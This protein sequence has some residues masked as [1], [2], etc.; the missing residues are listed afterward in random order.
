LGVSKEVPVG[1]QNIRLIVTLDTDAS[2]EQ[3]TTLLRLTE[4]YCV[5]YQTLLHAAKLSATYNRT[6]A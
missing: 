2:D 1:F 5:V 6:S 4:R 3:I